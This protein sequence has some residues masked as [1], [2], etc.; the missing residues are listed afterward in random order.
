MITATADRV[1]EFFGSTPTVGAEDHHVD[2][3]AVVVDPTA[4]TT[5]WRWSQEKSDRVGIRGLQDHG[6]GFLEGHAWD[7]VK[8]AIEPWQL[9]EPTHVATLVVDLDEWD[10]RVEW[11][12]AG[13]DLRR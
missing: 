12:D 13:E 1:R 6:C 9:E 3:V 11:T 5:P 2:R 10:Y 4:D 8:E 7:E